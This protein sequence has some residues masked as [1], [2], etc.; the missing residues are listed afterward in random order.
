MSV[1]AA[2]SKIRTPQNSKCMVKPSIS[3]FGLRVR[4][5]TINTGTKNIRSSVNALGRF[6]G[7][8]PAVL[9]ACEGE[10]SPQSHYRL[11][12]C[13]RQRLRRAV[14]VEWR[15]GGRYSPLHKGFPVEGVA[16]A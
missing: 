12:T 15:C 8:E 2:V 9:A 1:A 11:R 3:I 13:G 5:T 7:A 16:C 4:S 14:C 10:K 6:M